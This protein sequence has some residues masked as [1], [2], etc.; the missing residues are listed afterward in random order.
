MI[1]GVLIRPLKIIPDSRGQIMHMLRSD[2]PGFAG[3]GEVYFSCIEPGAIK[4]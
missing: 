3:F 2:S 1:D 4:A